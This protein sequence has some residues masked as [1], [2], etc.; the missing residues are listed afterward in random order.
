MYPVKRRLQTR[1]T[2]RQVAVSLKPPYKAE[3]KRLTQ[4]EVIKEVR[5]HTEW[6]N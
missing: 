3:L 2:P 6:I 4:L 5:E 1:S